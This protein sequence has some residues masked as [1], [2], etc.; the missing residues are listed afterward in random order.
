MVGPMFGGHDAR[1][2]ICII[3]WT[4]KWVD[5]LEPGINQSLRALRWTQWPPWF[6]GSLRIQPFHMS[7]TQRSMKYGEWY[8]E[9]SGPWKNPAIWSLEGCKAAWECRRK[10]TPIHCTSALC[11]LKTLMLIFNIWNWMST[12]WFSC[13][14][15]RYQNREVEKF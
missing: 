10:G 1:S 7:S 12:S 11:F 4:L 9:M 3:R 5:F 2:W 15:C 8:L 13:L 14:L 6:S